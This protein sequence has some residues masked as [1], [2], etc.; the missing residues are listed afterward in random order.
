MPVQAY[1][2]PT[3]HAW[4]FSFGAFSFGVM[5]LK[6][7]GMRL[8]MTGLI[9]SIG[10]AAP[11]FSVEAQED[12][13]E[14]LTVV[15]INGEAATLNLVGSIINQLPD[16]LRRQPIESY[17][18]RIVDDIID[19]RLTAE[20]AL[21]SELGNNPLLLELAQRA[22]DRVLAEAWLND[23][24]Q[25]RITDDMI[26][27]RYQELVADTGSRD[28]IKARHILVGS[29]EEAEA[30]IG[31]LKSGED[32][33]D[34]AKELSTGTSGPNGGDLGY[35]GRGA[36]VPEFEEASFTLEKGQYTE[37]PVQTQFGWHVIVVEDRR[38]APAPQ[39][40]DIRDQLIN[41]MSVEVAGTIIEELRSKA[42]IERLDFQQVRDAEAKRR[43]TADQ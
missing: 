43:A 34:L 29:M 33:S 23:E 24:I 35:F 37:T 17:Y 32:F 8:I 13:D 7:L 42:T 30:A 36:M 25:D 38:T 20:A 12:D 6:G 28:E 14:A 10:L 4:V 22:S 27:Q 31:R 5:P 41:A 26:Q 19:T 3:F 2:K 21:A 1:P 15:T 9:A 11:I 18:D 40:Q 16:E 39:L